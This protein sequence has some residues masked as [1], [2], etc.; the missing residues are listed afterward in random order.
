MANKCPLKDGTIVYAARNLYNAIT[1]EIHKFD[2]ACDDGSTLTRGVNKQVGMIRLK[3]PKSKS[4][5]IANHSIFI[6]PNPAKSLVNIT[7]KHIISRVELINVL[8]NTI[9]SF[10]V[11]KVKFVQLNIR[12][13][14]KGVYLV[15][16]TTLNNGILTQKLIIE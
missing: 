1:H 11:N 13:L 7:T 5:I 10:P 8:G 12:E 6:Y 14:H 15:K 9:K 16:I 4:I 3:Q 2:N